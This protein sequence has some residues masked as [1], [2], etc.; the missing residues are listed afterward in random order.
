[1]NNS[2]IIYKQTDKITF[3]TYD[4]G[5]YVDTLFDTQPTLD[6]MGNIVYILQNQNDQ[7]GQ[8]GQIVLKDKNVFIIDNPLISFKYR[9]DM[10]CV[11]FEILNISSF[12]VASQS[13]LCLHDN[14]ITSGIVID[15]CDD[16]IYAVPIYEEKII[17]NITEVK[18]GN[19]KN[20]CILSDKIKNKISIALK[21]CDSEY[22]SDII[23]NIIY[24]SSLPDAMLEKIDNF[25]GDIILGDPINGAKKI[26]PL[27]GTYK[28]WITKEKY[29]Q[30][31]ADLIQKKCFN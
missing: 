22:Q 14:D 12:Y 17:K 6:L 18:I 2:I 3:S 5:A 8:N 11:M 4:N 29:K 30:T 7:N 9:N 20:S 10:A 15:Y 31:G 19:I 27:L 28:Y 16:K 24:S 25:N 13:M 21:G 26:I 23:D 1:M